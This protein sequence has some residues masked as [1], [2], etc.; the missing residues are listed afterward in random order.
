MSKILDLNNFALPT[1]E[2]T[3]AGAERTTLHITAPSEALIDEMMTWSKTEMSKLSAG[4]KESVEQSYDLVARLLSCNLER[5]ELTAETLR[6]K[7]AE[8]DVCKVNHVDPL[9][10]LIRIVKTYLEFISEIEN[11]KN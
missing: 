3:F 9:W 1:M 8:T 11:E 6:A 4:D 5:V 7:I 2:L 10:V